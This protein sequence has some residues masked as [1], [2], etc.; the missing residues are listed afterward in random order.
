MEGKPMYCIIHMKEGKK[1]SIHGPFPTEARAEKYAE[2]FEPTDHY[3]VTPLIVPH[4]V[5]VKL[6]LKY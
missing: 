6:T 4:C 1:F 5:N 2:A 3:S